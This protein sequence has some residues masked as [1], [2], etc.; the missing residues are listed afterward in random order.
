M[1]AQYFPLILAVHVTLALMLFLPSILLP[2][3]MRSRRAGRP[4]SEPTR[5]AM[6]LQW[7]QRNGTLVIGIGLAI[8]GAAMV[9]VL[10]TQLLSQPWLLV[11]LTLYTVNLLIAFFV[12][13]PGLAR[14]LRFRGETSEEATMRW[15]TWARRQRYVSY[16]M[17]GLV[18]VIGFLMMTKPDL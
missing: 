14:L 13:R 11:A 17:A 16:V 1:L 12:Q 15:R 9:A 10:G 7:M 4:P 5:F 2:F 6:V 3:T 8:T 18:G